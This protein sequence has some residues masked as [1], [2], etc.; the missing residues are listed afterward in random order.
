M[1]EVAVHQGVSISWSVVIFPSKLI[2]LDKQ[3]QRICSWLASVLWE[4]PPGWLHLGK[5]KNMKTERNHQQNVCQ[6][7]NELITNYKF[8]L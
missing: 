1:V 4:L 6:R 7:L 2:F 8:G 5:L 3:L